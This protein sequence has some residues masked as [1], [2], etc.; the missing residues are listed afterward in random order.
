MGI[1]IGEVR[2]R[3]RLW[4]PQGCASNILTALSPF[5]AGVRARAEA[6]SLHLSTTY[7]IHTQV[8]GSLLSHDFTLGEQMLLFKRLM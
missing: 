4:V 2:S 3:A 6:D 7:Y 8:C 1:K 5:S